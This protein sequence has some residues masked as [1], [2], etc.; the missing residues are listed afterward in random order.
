M[1]PGHTLAYNAR[2][3]T[4]HTDSALP[5]VLGHSVPNALLASRLLRGMATSPEL[6]RHGHYR[7]DVLSMEACVCLAV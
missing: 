6:T 4:A 7:E 2:Y 1:R 3:P 5:T